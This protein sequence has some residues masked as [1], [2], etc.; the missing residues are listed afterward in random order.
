MV[1][2]LSL[3]AGYHSNLQVAPRWPYKKVLICPEAF[4]RLQQAQGKL[5]QTAQLIITRG[6]EPGNIILRRLH[7]FMRKLGAVVFIL[8]YPQRFSEVSEIFSSNGHDTDGTHVDVAVS[9]NAKLLN[10][11]P[12]GV[13]THAVTIAAIEK[14]YSNILTVVRMTLT[15]VGFKT[16]SN[17]TE[18]LQIHCDMML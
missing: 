18:A 3:P 10:L 9:Q 13:L 12:S 5:G 8:C 7:S 2:Y 16:H 4:S 11:L 14:E 6:F 17:Q 15:E 1:D